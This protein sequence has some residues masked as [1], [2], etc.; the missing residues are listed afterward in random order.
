[1]YIIESLSY[2]PETNTTL[3]INYRSILRRLKKEYAEKEIG[4][5]MTAKK[6]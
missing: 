3:Q 2:T 6:I 1:M 5:K 4:N